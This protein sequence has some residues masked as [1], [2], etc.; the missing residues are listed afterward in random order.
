M[1]E[2]KLAPL[3][4]QEFH[5]VAL[6]DGA[7]VSYGDILEAWV[8]DPHF[9]AMLTSELAQIPLTAFRWE[10][11]P[12]CRQNLDRP[13]EFVCLDCP[14][15]ERPA[16]SRA[17][18][19]HFQPLSTGVV[20][21]D[22]LGRDAKLVIPCPQE[23]DEHYAHLGRFL[24]DGDERQKQELWQ[25]VGHAAQARL[26]DAPMWIST[27]GMGVAWLHVRIDDAPK[28]YGHAPYRAWPAP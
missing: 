27:A 22:N 3:P 4:G 18:E 23:S 20:T 1:W 11:P 12:V 14:S 7:P 8:H 9:N 21:V 25:A 28:Y 2:L 19:D 26:S 17:F 15:L 16:D 6:R 13:F 5:Y 10:T 24:R